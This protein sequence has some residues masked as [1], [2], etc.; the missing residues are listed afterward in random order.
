MLANERVIT[1]NNSLCKAFEKIIMVRLGKSFT[2]TEAQAG[3]DTKRCKTQ[4]MWFKNL[5]AVCHSAYRNSAK[6]AINPLY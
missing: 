4:N 3:A 6:D 5:K 1:L 2:F